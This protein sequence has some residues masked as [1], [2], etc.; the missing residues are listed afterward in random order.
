MTGAAGTQIGNCL[1]TFNYDY[2]RQILNS[3]TI[4]LIISDGWDRGTPTS[5]L[6]N[7]IV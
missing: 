3:R 1:R 7:W 4:V 2:G 6:S 5:S